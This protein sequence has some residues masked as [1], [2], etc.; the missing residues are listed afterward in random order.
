MVER[1]PSSRWV[2]LKE[3]DSIVA[4][5]ALSHRDSRTAYPSQR[6]IVLESQRTWISQS[7][8]S[9]ARKIRRGRVTMIPVCYIPMY[10]YYMRVFDLSRTVNRLILRPS[11]STIVLI[12]HENWLHRRYEGVTVEFSKG[13]LKATRDTAQ[14]ISCL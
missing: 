11:L 9:D 2:T 7:R 5:V 1:T 4:F 8:T 3:P 12:T 14:S 6:S 13:C 10:I